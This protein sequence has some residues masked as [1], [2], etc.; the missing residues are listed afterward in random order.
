MKS[1]ELLKEAKTNFV[2]E[3][4][5]THKESGY[6][7]V[8]P[9][10]KSV[11]F[12]HNKEEASAYIKSQHVVKASIIIAI[13]GCLAATICFTL[14]ISVQTIFI[15]GFACIVF[16]AALLCIHF[17]CVKTSKDKVLIYKHD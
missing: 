7:F 15:I 14:G 9:W 8:F 17:D 13:I 2:K 12:A 11:L 6:S 10:R 5:K 1:K 4:G 16:I 3:F